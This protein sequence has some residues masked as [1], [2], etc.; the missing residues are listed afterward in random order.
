MKDMVSTPN[1]K[2]GGLSDFFKHP[3]ILLIIGSAIT[4]Y[5]LP[6]ILSE[7]AKKESQRNEKS[8]LAIEF[9]TRNSEM[10]E[11]FNSLLVSLELFC[12]YPSPENFHAEQAR[13]RITSKELYMKFD[14]DVW[15]WHWNLYEKAKMWKFISRSDEPY[16]E[17]ALHRYTEGWEMATDTLEGFWQTC[18]DVNYHPGDKKVYALMDKTER[19]FRFSHAVRDTAIRFIVSKLDIEEIKASD[20]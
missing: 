8:A 13:L 19:A 18:L 9:I 4:S 15:W 3:L 14:R 11:D 5:L 16:V 10:E 1:L 17:K 7:V 2:F 12:K 20:Q 6:S